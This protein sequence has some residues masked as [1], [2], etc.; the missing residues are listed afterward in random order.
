MSLNNH[1]AAP[2]RDGKPA[3][4][5][6]TKSPRDAQQI[7]N[8]LLAY[9]RRRWR[10]PRLTF[11]SAPEAIPHGWET[12]TY[13]FQMQKCTGLPNTLTCPLIA[14]V[15]ASPVGLASAQREWRVEDYLRPIGFPVVK[16]LFLEEN[17]EVF[18]GPFLISE[19]AEGEVF[20]DYLYHHPWRILELPRSMGCLHAELHQIPVDPSMATSETFLARHLSEMNRSIREYDLAEL[21]TGYRWLVRHQ[22]KSETSP[23]FLHLDF[24]P[25][26]LLYDDTRGF[27]VLDWSRVDVGD[28][29]ADVA[30]TKM[31][32]DCMQIEQT[33]WWARFNYWG[34]R[35]FLRTGYLAAYRRH[36]RLNP[37]TLAYYSSWATLRRLCTY[38]AWLKAGPA[39][40]GTKPVSL[41]KLTQAHVDGF[42][43]YFEHHTGVAVALQIDEHATA[44]PGRVNSTV[45]SQAFLD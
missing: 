2:C 45:A 29:H 23:A 28:R 25:L 13:R 43:R 36:L 14:R 26:N 15:Y 16:C 6:E 9:L 11:A 33:G 44:R 30:V 35:Y 24:H 10:L 39:A 37:D 41:R 3:I 18:G 38:G 21:K 31:F 4:S 34:G 22:P 1:A 40:C 20:P 5:K 42:C 27:T 7:A 19:R 17:C 12:Y 8:K 32:L